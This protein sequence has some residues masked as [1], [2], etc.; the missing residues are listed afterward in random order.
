[1]SIRRIIGAC[2]KTF[3]SRLPIAVATVGILA[4]GMTT[5]GAAA[6]SGGPTTTT[7]S[8]TTTTPRTTGSS[9]SAGASQIRPAVCSE[10]RDGLPVNCPKPVP[11]GDLPT[12]AKNKSL[13]TP[14]TTDPA[15][16]VDTRTWTT[17]GGNT[18]PGADVPFGMVQWSPD[19]VPNRSA[20]G[21]Y[22]YGDS[23]LTGYSLTHV[24]GP[25]CGAAGDIPI[26]PITGSLPAGNPNDVTTAFSND[27][28]VAQAGYYSAQSNQPNTITSRV[29]RDAAQLDGPLHLPGEPRRPVS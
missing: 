20:G 23:S 12:R 18:F 8:P 16:L 17:G 13:M 5:A 4:A 2:R 14:A 3:R 6:G 11:K 28:E 15:T 22:T 21:G 25:G 29:H 19:T 27:G 10:G 24:S 9:T 1:M 26:L 7:A